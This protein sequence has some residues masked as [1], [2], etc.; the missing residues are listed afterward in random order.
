MR[1]IVNASMSLP[2]S[3]WLNCL[4]FQKLIRYNASVDADDQNQSLTLSANGPQ[5]CHS[6]AKINISTINKHSRIELPSLPSGGSRI[7]QTGKWAP[8]W[9]KTYYLTRILPKTAWKWKK[10]D[11]YGAPVPSVP[12]PPGIHQC[13]LSLF[14]GWFDLQKAKHLGQLRIS[15]FFLTRATTFFTFW[16]FVDGNISNVHVFP[17]SIKKFLCFKSLFASIVVT[18][19]RPWTLMCFQMFHKIPVSGHHLNQQ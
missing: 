6:N 1:V 11:R 2:I 4:H 15:G 12:P 16:T 18:S 7:S 17:V 5:L 9:A 3:L 14:P 19:V 10:L 8:T 13:F